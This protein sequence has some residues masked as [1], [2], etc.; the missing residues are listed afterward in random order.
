MISDALKRI[1]EGALLKEQGDDDGTV[2]PGA[3]PQAQPTGDE[4]EDGEYD[5]GTMLTNE[6]YGTMI[7]SHA[8][9]DEEPDFMKMIRMG[10]GKVCPPSSKLHWRGGRLLTKPPSL[11][12]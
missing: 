7:S 9:D 5:S 6:E 8:G 12:R 4:D 10:G 2:K 1:A 11:Y 3:R